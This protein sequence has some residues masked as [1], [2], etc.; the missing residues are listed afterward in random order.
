MD[1]E[2]PEPDPTYLQLRKRLLNLHPE[3]IGL[4]SSD[5]A[6][7]VWG[8][9]METGYEV[10]TAT[11]VALADGT[12][13][14]YYSTG[15]G[16]LGSPEYSPLA[17]SSKALVSQANLYLSALTK[18]DEIPLPSAGQV[19]FIF[20]TFTGKLSTAVEEK[21]LTNGHHPLAPLYSQAHATLNHLRL[22]VNK[23]R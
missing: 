2:S 20:L 22:L 18:A 17:E 9:M 16:M 6:S 8:M 5:Q 23:K 21:L 7:Q 19:S 11:L 15:G 10:G 3:D 4:H 13:S 12:T 14:L 1:N